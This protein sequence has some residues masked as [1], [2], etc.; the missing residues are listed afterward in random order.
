MATVSSMLSHAD[1]T[2]TC[3]AGLNDAFDIDQAVGAQL[4]ILGQILGVSR[5][6]NFQ[7]T[8]AFGPVSGTFT[9]ASVAYDYLTGAQVLSGVPRYDAA[10]F[11]QGIMFEETTVNLLTANQSNIENGTTGFTGNHG[12]E[13]LTQDNT[14]AWQGSHSLKVVTPGTYSREGAMINPASISGNTYTFSVWVRG[15]GTV[16]LIT[17]SPALYSNTITLT[18]IWTRY[19]LTTTAAGSS[20]WI[21]VVTSTAQAITFWIDGL[22]FEQKAYA[23][24]WTLGSTTRATES[25]T[26][27]T[28]GVFTPG[29]W[30]VETIY[31]PTDTLSIASQGLWLLQNDSGDY[32]WLFADNKQIFLQ[33]ASSGATIVIH[34]NQIFNVGQSYA[35]MIAGN[36]SVMRLCVNGVQIGSDIAYVEPAGILAASM[37]LNAGGSSGVN[38]IIDDLRISSRARTLVEHQAYVN[39]GVAQVVDSATTLLLPFDGSTSYYVSTSPILDDATY[40]LVLK[41]R[42]A[43]NMWDGTTPGIYSLFASLF[44]DSVYL[45]LTDNQNMTCDVLVIGLSSVLQQNLISNGFIIPRPEGVQYLYYYPV[46]PVFAYGEENAVFQGY[47]QGY[48]VEPA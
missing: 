44:P 16:D 20:M 33:V 6:V 17:T 4:D 11:N 30:A 40:Q 41:A 46:N 43:Q 14:Y 26:I 8:D 9:R 2:T 37:M 47:G 32:Y 15:S 5:V 39:G 45:I 42:I 24:S 19:S 21:G 10:M 28:A 12:D 23:T 38:G 34:S 35:I 1:D 3:A 36:G 18:S 22:Q 31:I 29:S 48:W 7:P 25:L 27:P 13:T